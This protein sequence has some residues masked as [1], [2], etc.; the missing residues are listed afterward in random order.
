MDNVF[1]VIGAVCILV[2]LVGI[3][4]NLI[5]IEHTNKI[6]QTVLACFLIVNVFSNNLSF[7]YEEI[8]YFEEFSINDED[9]KNNE[10]FI[11]ENATNIL[12]ENIKT[13]L[14]SKNLSYTDVFVHIYK[15]NDSFIIQEIEI[16]GSE[17]LH[18]T[19]II[20]TLEDIA[21]KECITFGGV[22]G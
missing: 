19:E 16:Y 15:Q 13:K 20:N 17:E 3:I 22:N 2:Y 1:S 11:I 10:E 9:L 12:I 6:I 14:K 8:F 7:N 5:K 4:L 18:K 21:P